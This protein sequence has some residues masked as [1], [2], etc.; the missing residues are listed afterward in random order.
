MEIVA[1]RSYSIYLVHIPT[2]FAMHEAWYRIYK[3]A[4]PTHRQ[5]VV[6]F[7]SRPSASRWSPS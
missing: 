7:G 6:Y 5:A 2:Y 4:V 1:A 3:F